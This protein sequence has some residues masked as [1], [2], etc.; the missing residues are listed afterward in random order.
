L[1]LFFS[2]IFYTMW[3]LNNCLLYLLGLKSLK[4]KTL[5]LIKFITF[6]LLNSLNN[7]LRLLITLFW[8][9]FIDNLRLSFSFYIIKAS[10]IYILGLFL[11]PGRQPCCR[12]SCFDLSKIISGFMSLVLY[13]S[14]LF[15]IILVISLFLSL[16]ILEI[17]FS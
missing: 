9:S 13:Y 2:L 6:I 8:Q 12:Y 5:Y 10:A 11:D 3:D 15:K 14:S 7:L 16:L 4:K 1:L 17:V